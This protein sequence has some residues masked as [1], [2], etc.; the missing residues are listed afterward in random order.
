LTKAVV[1]SMLPGL[2]LHRA[3][4]W[5]TN[6]PGV[7]LQVLEQLKI[8]VSDRYQIEGEIGRGGMATVFL[9]HDARHDRAVAL[10]VLNPELAAVLGVERFL[11]EIKV[12]AHLQH[13]NLLPL[14]D[15]GEA[16][17]LLYYVMPFVEGESLRALLAR[18]KQLP[19]AQAVHIAASVA[20][21]LEY[22]HAHGVVHRDLKPENI[23]LQAG[24]PLVADFGIALAVSNAGGARIT[25]TGLSLGTPQYMS[26]EQATGE[27][28]VDGRSDVYGLGA[29]LYEMLTGDPPHTGSTTRAIVAKVLTD[30]P[31]P[32]RLTRP[33]APDHLAAAV[34][35]ALE[36]LPADRFPSAAAFSEAITGKS[37]G[38][39]ASALPLWAWHRQLPGLRWWLA[40]ALAV[41][42]ATTA[43]V[44]WLRLSRKDPALPLMH[45]A[46]LP[47][48][49]EDFMGGD[50]MA[51]SADG[52][53]LAF[54]VLR[55]P[56]RPRLFV[57]RLGSEDARE[58]PGTASARFPFWSPDGQRIGYFA[59]GEL[60]VIGTDGRG[61]TTIARAPTPL[62]GA[63]AP[64]GTM[65]FAS[66]PGGVIYR[67]R[68]GEAPVAVTKRGV[69]LAHERPMVLP[70]G[71]HFLFSGLRRTG[72][73]IGDLRTGEQ[74]RI[75]SAGGVAS[76][77]APAH[78]IFDGSHVREYGRLMAQRFD[79]DG[80]RVLGE[81][82]L[83]ADSV[84]D[85]AGFT[86]YAVSSTGILV[87]QHSPR[88]QPRLWLD[89]RGTV[90]DSMG[91]DS[92]WTHRLSHD[93]RFVAQGGYVLSV[94]DLRRGVVQ[95]LAGSGEHVFIAMY[96][97]WSP[98]D[99][100]I[101]FVRG[102]MGSGTLD[103]VRADG[104][105]EPVDVTELVGGF[106]SA[107]Q[108]WTSD[109]A[110]ILATGPASETNPALALW[111]ISPNTKARRVLWL[112]VSG[113]IASARFSPNG[114]WIAYQSDE[115][116]LPE[117][118]VR[119][120]P[121]P[122]APV[123]VSP[124]GGGIPTWR[125][126]GRELFYLN[127]AGDLMSVAVV[128]DGRFNAETPHLLM[129]GVTRQPYSSFVTSYDP[130]PDGQRFF[131]YTENRAAAPP[132]TLL[133]PW[134]LALRPARP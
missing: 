8:A 19:I 24:E 49:G 46:L 38:V 129:R 85:P 12:T 122:G 59:D 28:L 72:V 13:P 14:F 107:P 74:R 76:F 88:S 110:A 114:R 132:L 81:A 125:A 101:A 1:S 75:L 128:T 26:P 39:S 11:A 31:R 22:A 23:L 67:L 83:L 126:D 43:T 78:L 130:A 35:T 97:V 123:R 73:F 77:A 91:R 103:V 69:E 34:E 98:D 29:V 20:G 32:V 79:P 95:Q 16:N 51:L 9:A 124:T 4:I 33:S 47:P 109:G 104:T 106:S 121:G 36:K 62:G 61:A 100:R 58:L 99:A 25:Q 2:V 21:A 45:A 60:R 117:V 94:R 52:T 70:D 93:G 44:A 7:P 37:V 84:S 102:T 120:F 17:G 115:T 90:L 131:V 48:P 116:G 54:T 127:P 40:T 111:L 134:P 89:R 42:A 112:A 118:Y 65:L 64:D 133:A 80:G 113:N 57:R 56:P 66:E 87:F 55:A 86:G 108:D 96:P 41:L 105:A 50:G 5:S 119:P 68:P 53:Q 18:E 71:H 10:K 15:S 6:L 30:K 82:I 3:T 92:A 63:W 27:R